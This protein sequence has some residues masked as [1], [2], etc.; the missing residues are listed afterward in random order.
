MS[1][2][3]EILRKYSL[4]ERCLN[5]L[6]TGR[7]GGD[8]G[9][10]GPQVNTRQGNICVLCRDRLNDEVMEEVVERALRVLEYFEFETFVVGA[11][12]PKYIKAIEEQLI[13]EFE[14][15]RAESVK[16]AIVRSIGRRI[17]EVLNRPVKFINPDLVIHVDIY[18][19]NVYVQPSHV[20]IYGRYLKKSGGIS[21]TPLYCWKCWGSGCEVCGYKGRFL[22]R[23]VAEMVGLPAQRLLGALGYKFHAAGREDVDARVEGEGRPFIVELISPRYRRLDTVLY[24][25]EVRTLSGGDVEV[26]DVVVSNRSSLRVLKERYERSTKHYSVVVEFDREIDDEALSR[27][28]STLSGSVVEQRTPMRVLRRRPDR[29][30]HKRVHGLSVRRVGQNQLEF[31]VVCDAGLYVKELIHGDNGRTVPSV[32]EILG[33]K[34]L[35]IELTVI[36]LRGE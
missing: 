27:L 26:K 29:I 11:L 15:T 16:K 23:S 28:I 10:A 3:S 35:R 25:E 19:G 34:P 22:E 18:T 7:S 24:A 6:I 32:S 4:C 30:R 2:E 9:G 17:S 36:G 12:V 14:L 13:S 21:H 31:D 1:V 5:R 8:L 33:T 20:Y